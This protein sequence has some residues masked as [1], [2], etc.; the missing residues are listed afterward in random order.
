MLTRRL[1]HRRGGTLDLLTTFAGCRL[2]EVSVDPAV[3]ISDHAL[4]ACSL[5]IQIGQ[6][7]NA[8][9]LVRGYDS[10]LRNVADSLAPQNRLRLRPGRAPAGGA[11]I[12]RR[13]SHPAS[14]LPS[15]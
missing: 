5:P 12:R 9:R 14:Q 2:D 1:T 13:L 11:V 3:V 7:V 8:E 6:A 4:V 15:S 10:V